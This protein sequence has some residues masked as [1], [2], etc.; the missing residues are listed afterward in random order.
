[1]PNEARIDS[2]SA[3]VRRPSRSPW[4]SVV[5]AA[6]ALHSVHSGGERRGSRGPMPDAESCARPQR[7]GARFAC[8]RPA[9]CA[10]PRAELEAAAAPRV[11]TGGAAGRP[12]TRGAGQQPS[13]ATLNRHACVWRAEQLIAPCGAAAAG[14]GPGRVRT[15]RGHVRDAGAPTRA[16]RLAPDAIAG[17][18]QSSDFPR[19]G[20]PDS[21]STGSC[22][23]QLKPP[24]TRAVLGCSCGCF[25]GAKDIRTRPTL[26]G[27]ASGMESDSVAGTADGELLPGTLTDFQYIDMLESGGAMT[28]P[29]PG[30][31]G[32]HMC[33]RWL[34][35]CAPACASC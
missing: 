25:S 19:F 28:A 10:S 18:S 11:R 26:H 7:I 6:G 34:A 17:V 16:W 30:A 9:V 27:D 24:A 31:R 29:G 1:M 22:I 8:Q 21:E 14:P 23:T 12:S 3:S 13:Q 5:A 32:S 4:R 35:L 2:S 33:V 20:V 15:S